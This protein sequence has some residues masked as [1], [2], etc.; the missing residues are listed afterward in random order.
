MMKKIAMIV[1]LWAGQ[2]RVRQKWQQ[3]DNF[4]QR[5]RV[6]HCRETRLPGD[7]TALATAAAHEGYDVVIAVGGDGT[8]NETIN[9]LMCAQNPPASRPRL[10]VLPLGSANDFARGL[11]LL[12]DLPVAFSR[13]LSDQATAVDLGFIVQP[14]GQ[15]R[16]FGFSTGLGFVGMVAAKRFH[17]RYLRGAPLYFWAALQTIREYGDSPCLYVQFDED[18]PI[19]E[20]FLFLSVN[21]TATVGGFPLTPH[22]HM[23]DGFL[24]V[25]CLSAVDKIRTLRLLFKAKMGAHLQ[26]PE[27]RVVRTRHLSINSPTSLPLHIDGEVNQGT[28]THRL[29]IGVLPGALQVIV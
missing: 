11:H 2:G 16:Y 17:T 12:G 25:V 28:A 22:A 14:T 10:G 6:I 26:E 15:I 19:L 9:G 18:P 27:F 20:A 1:N 13:I 24:D 8:V 3:I 7:A 4:R 21:N 29:E 5:H 23:D